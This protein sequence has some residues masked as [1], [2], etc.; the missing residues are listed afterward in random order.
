MNEYI[1][2][3]ENELKGKT[4]KIENAEELYEFLEESRKI[5]DQEWLYH[6]TDRHALI[7]RFLAECLE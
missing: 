1:Q 5:A 3:I 4:I 2:Q 6:C 7:I